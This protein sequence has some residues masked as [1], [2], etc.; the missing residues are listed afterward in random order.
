MKYT[1]IITKVPERHHI[2]YE[3]PEVELTEG[4][5]E[6]LIN[7]DGVI[8]NDLFNKLEGLQCS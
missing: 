7:T 4:E 5:F 1:Y 3:I 8:P 2:D 6:V